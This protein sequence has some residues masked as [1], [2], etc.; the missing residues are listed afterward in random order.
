MQSELAFWLTLFST[1]CWPLCF[2]WMHRISKR[3]H[4]VLEE[5]R[6][7]GDR[8]EELSRE[9]HDLIQ[10]VEPRVAEIRTD[11]TKVREVVERGPENPS[12][13]KR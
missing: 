11:V 9:E 10:D 13:S 12:Q 3:Q 2:W 8:I 4:A 1:L 5:L 6:E 7:Q